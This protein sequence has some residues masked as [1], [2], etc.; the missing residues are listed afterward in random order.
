VAFGSDSKTLAVA[1]G[2]GV[3]G[4]GAGG[5]ALIDTGHGGRGAENMIAVTEGRVTSLAVSAGERAMAAGFDANDGEDDGLVLWNSVGPERL[6]QVP[7]EVKE[8]RVSD[9]AFGTDGKTVA[10]GYVGI[11]GD[12]GVVVW[13]V[14]LESWQRL[15]SQI[16]NRNLSRHE[17]RELFP[18]KTYRPTFAKL[19]VPPEI[20]PNDVIGSR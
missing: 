13:D 1:Y 9:V 11:L 15:A 6:V 14:D 18:N 5:V 12:G 16:A 2:I 4:R 10:A 17:W 3:S 7:F 19:P 8:R 20:D